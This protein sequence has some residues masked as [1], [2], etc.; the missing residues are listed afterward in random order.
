MGLD[1]AKRQLSAANEVVAQLTT[2]KAKALKEVGDA[3]KAV[4]R[5]TKECTRLTKETETAEAKLAKSVKSLN[6]MKS[7]LVASEN[8]CEELSDQVQDL[9]EQVEEMSGQVEAEQTKSTDNEMRSLRA[10]SQKD[11]TAVSKAALR[12]NTLEK[13]V[14]D[15]KSKLLACQQEKKAKQQE[16]A[17]L[18]KELNQ[19][20]QE[21][22]DMTELRDAEERKKQELILEG[23]QTQTNLQYAWDTA[24]VE[25]QNAKLAFEAYDHEH[26]ELERLRSNS[27]HWER[28]AANSSAKVTAL[29]HEVLRAQNTATEAYQSFTQA[30]SAKLTTWFE[31]GYNDKV[32]V[33]TQEHKDEVSKLTKEWKAKRSEKRGKLKAVKANATALD[34]AL[35]EQQAET[36]RLQ[37]EATAALDQTRQDQQAE[38]LSSQARITQLEATVKALQKEVADTKDASQD[39]IKIL[40]ENRKAQKKTH[41]QEVAELRR[42]VKEEG[43]VTRLLVG[44]T[45][46]TPSSNRSGYLS[47]ACTPLRMAS[48]DKEGNEFLE[49]VHTIEMPK[50]NITPYRG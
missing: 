15:A 8:H 10:A 21:I 7:E 17:Q 36:V 32:N 31:R 12:A 26:G 42:K 1:T 9:S 11:Q 47:P 4:E 39:R 27:W 14:T 25:R 49:K 23:E 18:A 3:K 50:H 46:N 28:E 6:V 2:E 48:L 41:K 44:R 5:V 29:K 40:E 13:Q 33:L 35:K 22:A 43:E 45:P 19:A 34:R 37:A 38:T 16:N 20:Q 30:E 24:N